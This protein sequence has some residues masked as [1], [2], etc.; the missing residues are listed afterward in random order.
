VGRF[1][2]FVEDDKNLLA[3]AQQHYLETGRLMLTRNAAQ[4]TAMEAVNR[5]LMLHREIPAFFG[6]R[7][8]PKGDRGW[9]GRRKVR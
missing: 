7:P 3:E 2:P 4:Q 1:P 8:R 5:D 6:R 9:P